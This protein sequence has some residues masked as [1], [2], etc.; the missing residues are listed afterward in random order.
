MKILNRLPKFARVERLVFT[1]VA[2]CFACTIAAAQEE[3][4]H[5][6]AG[7][8]LDAAGQPSADATVIVCK[9]AMDVP[10][11]NQAKTDAAG[12]F[13]VRVMAT[14]Q[15]FEAMH[16]E[17]KSR[18]G[19]E[20]GYRSL[21][22][23]QVKLDVNSL[24]I[25]LG[26]VK[27]ASAHVF[28]A[29]DQPVAEATVAAR[30]GSPFGRLVSTTTNRD[31]LATIDYT[32][33]EPIAVAMAFK[34][35][36]GL[37]YHLFKA[38]QQ[39]VG[40]EYPTAK[41][42]RFLL[43]GSKTVKIKVVDDQG[44]PQEGIKVYPLI[45]QK[46]ARSSTSNYNLNAS[47]FSHYFLTETNAS[48]EVSFNWF[49]KWQEGS[50]MFSTAGGTELMHSTFTIESS[51]MDK[52]YERKLDRAVA[53]RGTVVGI[54]GLP[55]AGVKVSAAGVGNIQNFPKVPDA[56]TDEFGM[57]E[58]R[59]APN[60]VYIVVVNDRR[61]G[62]TPQ[63]GFAVY[64][65]TPVEG[66]DF[67]LRQATR[68]HGSVRTAFNLQPQPNYRLTL[69]QHGMSI[70]EVPDANLP[71][72]DPARD[73]LFRDRRPTIL[74]QTVSDENGNFE[75][76]VGDG[77][78]FAFASVAAQG[79]SIAGDKSYEANVVVT[80]SREPELKNA[81]KA[82]LLGMVVEDGTDQPSR[83]CRVSIAARDPSFRSI[84]SRTAWEAT[85]DVDGKFR[86]E[87]IRVGSFAHAISSNQQKAAIVE[88]KNDKNVFVMKL[89]DV[90]SASGKL[91]DANGKPVANQLL[92]C[93]FLVPFQREPALPVP[94]APT[95]SPHFAVYSKTDS[96]GEFRFEH[97]VP[98]VEYQIFT[99]PS[100]DLTM[101]LATL[102]VEPA[103]QLDL[104]ELKND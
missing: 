5:V 23:E 45:L 63:N 96:E 8:V 80:Q 71:Q 35:H 62:S 37:D 78:R 28:D 38:A 32:D 22:S 27:Q 57:Y 36:L 99:G 24:S 20:I 77:E 83:D 103:Q 39:G 10:E 42:Q 53:V 85:T 68:V 60:G 73:V 72:G 92:V 6:V 46:A 55:A 11:S 31:G 21:R 66:K 26:K 76:F 7:Q 44:Q 51:V 43:Q 74:Y 49:P 86:G 41:P 65:N 98:N 70:A 52:V 64:P 84:A 13:S 75:F 19:T 18:D 58:L 101:S 95:G 29:N 14:P 16:V 48:G 81:A 82:A 30:L 34:D 90:G 15:H 67:Q 59:V 93:C 17:V 79:F 102:K 56:V 9:F 104:G 89:R 25:R 2:V 100:L 97:L 87:R 69:M 3:V 4:E 40:P 50:V 54:D 12:H 33:D 47:T 61:W 1:L 91:V 88:I 94:G